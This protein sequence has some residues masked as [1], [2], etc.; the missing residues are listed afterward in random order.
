[1]RVAATI[2]LTCLAGAAMAQPTPPPPGDFPPPTDAPQPDGQPGEMAPP[3]G[4]P[5]SGGPLSG[6]PLSGGV[7]APGYPQG[8]PPGQGG[9]RMNARQRFEMANVT[10]DGRLTRD[11]A[12]QARW[13]G[14]A[15]HFDDIDLD[16]KGYI[17]LQDLREWSRARR[18]SRQQGQAAPP[19][20][21]PGQP[22]Q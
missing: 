17:T 21:Q 7:G 2:L 18:A 22:Y 10:H 12:Q 1:M 8:L 14:V 20:P 5:P 13:M 4:G 16:R 19:T 3:P 6:G 9:V 15:R 11:Q